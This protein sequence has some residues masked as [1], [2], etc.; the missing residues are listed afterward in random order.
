MPDVNPAMSIILRLQNELI[1]QSISGPLRVS[2]YPDDMGRV[3]ITG[4]LDL[5]ALTDVAEQSIREKFGKPDASHLRN[6]E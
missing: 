2:R 6:Q 3:Q 4:R 1:R 5:A